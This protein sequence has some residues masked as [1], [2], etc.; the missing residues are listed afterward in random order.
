MNVLSRLSILKRLALVLSVVILGLLILSITNLKLQ[1]SALER[2]QYE[3][4]QHV[5]ENAHSLITH[6]YDLYRAGKL[7][8]EDAQQKALESI[9]ALRYEGDNYFWVNDFSPAMV[10]HPMKPELNGKS[11]SSN[12]DPDGKRLFVE[13]VEVVVKDGAGFVPYKWPKPGQEKPVDKISYVKGF[14]PWQ[15]I[16]GSGVYLDTIKASFAE[17]RNHLIINVSLI[18]LI[19]GALSVVIG[20]SIVQ[21]INHAVNM[22]K[23]IAQGEGD[24]TQRLEVKGK[25]EITELA[26]YFNLYTEK[27]RSSIASVANNAKEADKLANHV[28]NASH[29]NLRFI[30]E[31]NDSSRQIATAVE[32]MSHQIREVSNNAIEADNAAKEA[33]VNATSGKQVVDK[34]IKAIEKLTHTI[35]E[36]SQVTSELA[37]QTNTIGSVLDVIRGISEQTNLLAL[38]AAIEAA[39]AGEQ[40][41]GFAVVADEVRTLA[42]RTGQS[43]DEIQVMIEKLQQGAKAAVNAVTQSQAISKDTV[44]QAAEANTVLEEIE[45][46]IHIISEMNSHIAHSADEQST[47]AQDVNKRICQ[48]SDSTHHSLDTTQALTSASERL[49]RASHDLNNVVTSFKI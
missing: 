24:L 18:I 33:I 29:K 20:R 9:A 7:T 11:L 37:T 43:T 1:Y 10:M 21:P 34:T 46:L 41:R 45:R 40:G 31:Q 25:D 13:M 23:S 15:W 3:K 27:M 6:Y 17:L 14:K 42:S 5:V 16:I 48:L 28:D 49:K 12:Q 22:M 19:V 39:R 26:S 4:T 47:V 36:V 44:S 38:N 35:E 8:E 32:Q 2:L 30:E